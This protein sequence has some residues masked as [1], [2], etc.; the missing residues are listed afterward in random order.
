MKGRSSLIKTKRFV[1]VAAP[2]WHDSETVRAYRRRKAIEYSEQL[3]FKGILFYSPL[4]YS[5]RF[6]DRKAREGFWIEH[7]LKMVDVCTEI[8]VLCLEGWQ[9]SR[10]IQ[11]E[12]ARAERNGAEVRYIEKH[13][14]ISVHGSRSLSQGQCLPVLRD[15][16]ERLQAECIVT[17]GETDGACEW[18][19]QFAKR[20]GLQLVTHHLQHWRQAGQFH[21][22]SV[23][24]L[25]DSERAIF[26]HDGKSDGTAN[27]LV[28]AK[29][30]GIAYE[31]YKPGSD[32]NLY[33]S[34]EEIHD[35]K[36]FE[37]NAGDDEFEKKLD[38]ATRQSPEYHRF[39][40]L[41][42]E[43]DGHKCRFCGA[44]ESLC[45]HHI[46]PFSKSNA[47]ATDVNNG[48]TLCDKCHRGVHG[49]PVL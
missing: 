16:A 12:V 28:L 43:R 4:M 31:Y 22:R 2:F 7:G 38:K 45:V 32:G 49:K 3:F 48:Q 14:R 20:E 24:V 46:I 36:D 6:K 34:Q 30:M 23:A 18:A 8:H 15:I 33:L 47:M 19:R 25:E 44:T 17:H 27:E 37:S 41:V 21:W 9:D 10:G 40:Q 29:K 1:Y 5:E 13:S 35:V 11:G 39:R 26:L 42:L